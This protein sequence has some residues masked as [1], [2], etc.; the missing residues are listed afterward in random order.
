[1]KFYKKGAAQEAVKPVVQVL[2]GILIVLGSFYYLASLGSL[3]IPKDIDPVTDANFKSL[4]NQIQTMVDNPEKIVVERHFPFQIEENYVL[5][6]FNKNEQT[7]LTSCV[8]FVDYPNS[9][10]TIKKPANKCG[11]SAC[12]CIFLKE[13]EQ[14]G[15]VLECKIYPEVNNFYTFQNPVISEGVNVFRQNF[16]GVNT[17]K[18]EE[19]YKSDIFYLANLVVYGYCDYPLKDTGNSNDKLGIINLYFEKLDKNGKNILITYES[20]QRDFD[21]RV[22]YLQDL[23]KTN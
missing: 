20:N 21:K 18:N 14:I 13:E 3:L 19:E 4:T 10:F 15:K 5:V 11:D 17:N 6:G 1:M 8:D 2:L 23:V 9:Y 22:K 7:S 12:L 16:R